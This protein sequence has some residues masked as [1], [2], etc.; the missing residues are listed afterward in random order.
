MLDDA[1][2]MDV[3]AMISAMS[4]AVQ[5]VLTGLQLHQA[6]IHAQALQAMQ[7]AE[8]NALPASRAEEGF[9]GGLGDFDDA[10]GEKVADRYERFK[11]DLA[12]ASSP[13]EYTR[14]ADEL[15]SDICALLRSLKQVSGGKLPGDRWYDVWTKHQCG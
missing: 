8:R 14:V 2:T 7:D 10:Y 3:F 4:A 11:R 5:A 6:N 9:W 1:G 13:G 12:G 15:N